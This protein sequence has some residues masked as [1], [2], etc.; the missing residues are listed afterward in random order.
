[1]DIDGKWA[2]V[3]GASGGLGAE[4]AAML[5]ERGANLV[6]TARTAGRLE[7][8]ASN[9]RSRFGVQIQT[10]AIDLAESTAAADLHDRIV[11][12]GIAVDILVN[13]AGQGLHG[14][15]LDRPIEDTDAMLQLNILGL[16]R[17]THA[18]GRQMSA[19]RTGYILLV[20]SMTA[21]MPS[22]SYA[23]YAASKSYVRQFGEAL[24]AELQPYGVVVTVVSPGLMD[25]G[26]LSAAGQHAGKRPT[27]SPRTAAE[28][29]IAALLAGRQSVVAGTANKF[30][31]F[32]TRLLSRRVQTAV[33]AKSLQD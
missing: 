11:R 26:F 18:I 5:A 20:A 13:N 17:L 1:M 16:T 31:A 28:T 23:A 6:L 27:M 15:F 21:Y 12:R 8:V 25:T 29:G 3:T 33:M 9:L 2:L 14:G 19:R 32:A 4:F 30:A 7:T 10:E 24:H 22:P